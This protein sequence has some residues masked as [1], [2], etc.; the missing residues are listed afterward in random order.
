MR[1]QIIFLKCVSFRLDVVMHYHKTIKALVDTDRITVEFDG[2][3][4]KST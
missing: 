2:I 1:S 4:N 3:T